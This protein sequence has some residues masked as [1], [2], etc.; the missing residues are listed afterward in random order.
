MEVD[1]RSLPFRGKSVSGCEDSMQ[2]P[3]Q[4]VTCWRVSFFVAVLRHLMGFAQ[5]LYSQRQAKARHDV[6]ERLSSVRN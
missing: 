2:D 5:G 3:F 4:S 1:L 6:F